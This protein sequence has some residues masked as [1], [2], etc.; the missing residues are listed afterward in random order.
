MSR[1]IPA[2]PVVVLFVSLLISPNLANAQYRT[3]IQGVVTDPTGAVIP[4]PPSL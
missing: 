3:S 4:G 1:S 2:A